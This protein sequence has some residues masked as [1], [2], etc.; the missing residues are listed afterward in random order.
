MK[1]ALG[2][3]F[4]L[5]GFALLAEA[6]VQYDVAKLKAGK[7][8][9]SEERY[10]LYNFVHYKLEH[11]YGLS[12]FKDKGHKTGWYRVEDFLSWLEENE[13]VLNETVLPLQNKKLKE[14]VAIDDE[15]EADVLA[16]FLGAKYIQSKF[17]QYKDL[18]VKI[19]NSS[20]NFYDVGEK[21]INVSSS[22][23]PFAA[24]VNT[25]MH[26][27]THAL[28]RGENCSNGEFS[29]LYSIAMYALPVKDPVEGDSFSVPLYLKQG[30]EMQRFFYK[31]FAFVSALISFDSLKKSPL[32]GWDKEVH[33]YVLY[34]MFSDLIAISNGKYYEAPDAAVFAW[35]NKFKDIN[36][37]GLYSIL[38]NK[39]L[40]KLVIETEMKGGYILSLEE[41]YA[42]KVVYA[43]AQRSFVLA[44]EFKKVGL[45]EYLERF[46]GMYNEA[47][48][49]AFL[50]DIAGEIQARPSFQSYPP[51]Y[52]EKKVP[53]S[54]SYRER[55]LTDEK[56][57]MEIFTKVFQKH[58]GQI[59]TP[60]VPEGYF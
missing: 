53:Y 13:A 30:V 21:T 50:R 31:Y 25:G 32:I 10:S 34:D 16:A 15:Y 46:S 6:E 45:E 49:K 26:E 3:I 29:V 37:K 48:S 9:L 19:K 60:P 11:Y 54:V 7:A 59:K 27:M 42:L 57:I 35:D 5:F 12:E 2:F 51:F 56:D 22:R 4:I 39:T 18:E 20:G 58:A 40:D 52:K 43:D 44:H 1:K 33:H 36:P 14:M 47:K 55:F 24:V 28:C 23:R 41:D 8:A 17:P 38:S